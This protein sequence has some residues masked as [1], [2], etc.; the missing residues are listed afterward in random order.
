MGTIDGQS[1]LAVVCPLIQAGDAEALAQ[2]VQASWKPLTICELLNDPDCDVR[3]AAAVVLGFVGDRQVVACLAKALRDVDPQVN[4]MAE[5]GL[6]SIWFQGGSPE[7]VPS[8]REGIALMNT[9]SYAAAIERFE[10]S[11]RIDPDFAEAFNQCSLAHYLLGHWQDAID[12]AR[13]TVRRVPQHFN[14]I[15]GMGHAYVQMGQFDHALKHYRQ[16]L[17]INPRM[18]G[19]ARV[20]ETLEERLRRRNDS[21]GMFEFQTLQ[22]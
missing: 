9:E 4:E 13:R 21:S 20:A 2:T 15:A 19:I 14:A 6:M 7:A 3:R 17:E 1:F 22:V 5:F 18:T 10:L 8:F 16:A 12:D 11:T